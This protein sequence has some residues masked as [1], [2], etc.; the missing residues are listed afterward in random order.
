[1]GLEI[2]TNQTKEKLMEIIYTDGSCRGNPGPGGWGWVNSNT[3]SSDGGKVKDTTNNR[4]ELTAVIKALESHS[5]SFD[6]TIIS[7]SKYVTDAFNQGWLDNWVSN[8]W[9][10]SSRKA[11]KN[12]DLW[13]E[14]LSLCESRNV[15]FEW[16]RGHDGN[17]WN[18]MAD[19]VAYN[20][21]GNI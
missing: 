21:S 8:N 19:F 11:V 3:N 2:Q 20:M 7:D 14:L 10:T 5:E 6:I 17:T 13:K 12:Q 9:R 18:E 15:I 16:V 4:M 1:M